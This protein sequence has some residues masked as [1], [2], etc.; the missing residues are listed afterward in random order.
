MKITDGQFHGI[1]CYYIL[2][3]FVRYDVKRTKNASLNYFI[4]SIL[5]FIFKCYIP[6]DNVKHL[7]FCCEKISET[8]YADI[9]FL[10]NQP[11]QS[12]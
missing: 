6:E 7:A 1:I 9:L 11:V 2:Y 5:L 8:S 12:I 4:F 10:T 3:S